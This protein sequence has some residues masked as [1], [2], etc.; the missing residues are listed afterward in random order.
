MFPVQDWHSAPIQVGESVP[1]SLD[2]PSGVSRDNSL[3]R[4]FLIKQRLLASRVG[5]YSIPVYL[6]SPRQERVWS[7]PFPSNSFSAP[8]FIILT[9]ESKT[10]KLT[11]PNA[12]STGIRL[13][14]VPLGL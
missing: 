10:S 11:G 6:Q 2:Q 7:C 12:S 4:D 5:S 13:S 8:H 14:F 9:V 3:K 1:D